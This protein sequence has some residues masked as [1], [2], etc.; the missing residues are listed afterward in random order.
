LY[1]WLCSFHTL[2]RQHEKTTPINAFINLMDNYILPRKQAITV[3][4]AFAFG[5]FLSCLLRAITAA[6][7]QFSL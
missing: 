7:S 4:F 3:F 5:Y 1:Y 6:F 2:E